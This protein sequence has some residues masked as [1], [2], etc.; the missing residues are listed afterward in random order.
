[1][2]HCASIITIELQVTDF[3]SGCGASGT[4]YCASI[5]MLDTKF[6]FMSA[7]ISEMLI[8]QSQ[9]LKTGNVDMDSKA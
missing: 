7:D 9:F 2:I 8:N 5:M 1:M 4:I 6:C 3:P